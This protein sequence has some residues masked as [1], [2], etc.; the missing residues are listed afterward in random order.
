MRRAAKVDA[1]QSEIVEALR[2]AGASVQLLHA[3]GKGCPDILVGYQSENYLLEIKSGERNRNR[4][5]LDEEVWID[6]WEGQV[7]VV[8]DPIDALMV[9]GA[10]NGA[11]A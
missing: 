8:C 4:L 1:S 10:I 6:A 11:Y 5:T 2:A 3:V 9:I 7:E